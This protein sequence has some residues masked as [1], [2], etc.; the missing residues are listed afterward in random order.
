M[1]CPPAVL[2]MFIHET[3]VAIWMRHFAY[4]TLPAPANQNDPCPAT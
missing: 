4:I 3:A 2:A 1:I